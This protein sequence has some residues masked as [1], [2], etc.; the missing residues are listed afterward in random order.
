MRTHQKVLNIG[1]IGRWDFE[2]SEYMGIAWIE[3]CNGDCPEKNYLKL[4]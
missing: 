1:K 4:K 2:K 3:V